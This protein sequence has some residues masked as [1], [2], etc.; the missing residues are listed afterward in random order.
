MF[1]KIQG[2]ILQSALRLTKEQKRET[3]RLEE[4]RRKEEDLARTKQI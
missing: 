1:K 2:A 3:S 4:K